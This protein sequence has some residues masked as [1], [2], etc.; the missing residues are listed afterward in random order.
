MTVEEFLNKDFPSKDKESISFIFKGKPANG[1]GP[2]L[3][4]EKTY[5]N[6]FMFPGRAEFYNKK[7]LL[8]HLYYEF[9]FV[10]KTV[11]LL[12]SI[13]KEFEEELL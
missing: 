3:V 8:S 2:Y 6:N 10:P 1:M 13:I 11:Y 9:G 7:D 12:N 4:V 5:N